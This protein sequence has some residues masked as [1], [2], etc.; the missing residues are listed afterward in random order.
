MRQC[1]WF[2]EEVLEAAFLVGVAGQAAGVV[3]L[4]HV[5]VAT[6]GGADGV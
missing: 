2:E 6:G 1:S 5:E 4:A 3:A